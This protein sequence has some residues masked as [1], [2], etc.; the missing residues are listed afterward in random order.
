MAWTL[1]SAYFDDLSH[2]RLLYP[3]F[4]CKMNPYIMNIMPNHMP[5]SS[6]HLGDSLTSLVARFFHVGD[7]SDV[8][9]CLVQSY[10]KVRGNF[11]PRRNQCSTQSTCGRTMK[12]IWQLHNLTLMWTKQ[13]RIW[14]HMYISIEIKICVKSGTK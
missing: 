5:F 12:L 11:V 3:L 13:Q 14:Y 10:P 6:G 2:L 8:T 9:K 4:L 7:S 1:F